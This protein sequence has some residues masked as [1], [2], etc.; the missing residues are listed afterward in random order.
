MD[1]ICWL[2]ANVLK[3]QSDCAKSQFVMMQRIRKRTSK[4][5]LNVDFCVGGCCLAEKSKNAERS[6]AKWPNA[7]TETF[8]KIFSKIPLPTNH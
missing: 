5:N 1:T 3:K 8:Q 2:N 7:T 6:V 4:A